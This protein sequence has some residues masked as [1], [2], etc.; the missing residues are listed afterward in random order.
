[1]Q[2]NKTHYQ[3]IYYQIFLFCLE[4][5]NYN[6]FYKIANL[7]QEVIDYHRDHEFKMQKKEEEIDD[8]KRKIEE[9]S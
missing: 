6:N 9:M 3:V 2:K 4:N 7:D 8:L 1:M 5:I